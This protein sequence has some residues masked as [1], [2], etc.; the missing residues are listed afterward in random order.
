MGNKLKLEQGIKKFL[1]Y[2]IP[3]LIIVLAIGFV[4][5]LIKTRPESPQ[6]SIEEHVW[7]VKNTIVSKQKLAPMITLYG[8]VETSGLFNA[9]A[10]AASQVAKVVIKEGQ[11]VE[12]GK[13]MISLDEKDFLPL[14]QQ[15]QGKVDELNAL[16]KS[17]E[18][19]DEVNKLSLVNERKLLK[20]SEKALVRAE[21]IKRKNLASVSETEQAMQ[22][23]EKQRLSYNA[24]QFSVREHEARIEQLK[25]RLLQAQADL[26]K[27]KLALERSQIYAPFS[28]VVAR[29]NVAQGDRVNTNEKLM[30]FYAEDQ[31]EIRANLPV[32][33]L[34]EIQQNLAEGVPLTGMVKHAGQWVPVTLERLS[35]EATASGMD[36]IFSVSREYSGL[37]IGAIAVVHLQRAAQE[38]LI[39][40]PY[41]S[42]YGTDRLYRI[43][44]GRLQSVKVESV[45]E[46]WSQ[47]DGEPELLVRSAELNAG[48]HI[49]STHLPNAINGLKVAIVNQ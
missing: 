24:M 27:N 8:R 42:L 48:D 1:P 22:Q 23:V 9:A 39:K 49:L 12:Q 30:S 3:V 31:L 38:D 40:V 44:D 16:I 28:G 35:G 7:R 13:L 36:A 10:P 37:R 26:E 25:A 15:A 18:L 43:V 11:F 34:K 4:K 17:E 5:M 32:N 6:V 46:Y 14:V 20:L 21:K 47:D 45:G 41:Q 29:V 33:L 2:L 19:R